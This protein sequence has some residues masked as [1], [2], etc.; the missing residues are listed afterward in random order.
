[1]SSAQDSALS[2]FLSKSEKSNLVVYE[3]ASSGYL[4][5]QLDLLFIRLSA[6]ILSFGDKASVN[7]ENLILPSELRSYL[8]KNRSISLYGPQIPNLLSP[9][10]KSYL[11]KYPRLCLSKSLNASNKLQSCLSERDYLA[12]SSQLSILI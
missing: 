3:K 11:L 6:Y 10:Y 12:F 1:M 9:S 8:L 7:S 5:L 4:A 2:I